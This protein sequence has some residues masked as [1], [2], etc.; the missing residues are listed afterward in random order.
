MIETPTSCS[1]RSN[2]ARSGQAPTDMWSG[3]LYAAV[4]AVA[5]ALAGALGSGLLSAGWSAGAVTLARIAVAAVVVT[6]LGVIALRGR[7]WL[8]RRNFWSIVGYGVLAV[9]GAQYCYFAAI[10]HIEVGP[11]LLIEY[12]APAAV[13]AWLWLRNG[14]RPGIVTVAGMGIASTG[15]ALVLNVVAGQS[16][17]P[18]GVGWALAAMFGS[19][20]YFL[21]SAQSAAG[22]PGLCLAAGG[23]LIA[24]IVL[25][26][27]AAVGVLPMRWST[28]DPRYAGTTVPA[29]LA[30]GLLGVVAAAL[31]YA[32]GIE[33]S[34]R[35]GSR[36]AAFLGLL[37]VVA[38]AACAWLL[39]GELPSELQGIGGVLIL[40][41]VVAVHSGE[42]ATTSSERT[43]S[44]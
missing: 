38:G 32:T 13:V 25:L 5:F 18:V 7:W 40:G 11:A 4:S 17:N 36:V 16:L 30:I 10:E 41:G 27:L 34:R 24:T 21:I 1:P 29:W 33:A 43:R 20:A 6:P 26:A 8:L 31:A 14:Q 15:L 37:E 39:L 44:G 23:F 28:M 42:Q 35:L 22:L 19:A 12:T 9:A 3:I 2:R